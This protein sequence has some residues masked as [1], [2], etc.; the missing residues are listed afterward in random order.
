MTS[1]YLAILGLRIWTR[2]GKYYLWL[3][4]LLFVIL[5]LFASNLLSVLTPGLDRFALRVVSSTSDIG[6]LIS[7]MSAILATILAI[8]FSISIVVIQNAASNYTASILDMYKKDRGTLLF[9]F[10]YVFS[11]IFCVV[12][13]E[14]QDLY[15]IN[16]AIVLF[17][18]AFL[19][20]FFQFLHIIDLIDPRNIIHKA[21][22]ES[23][24][25]IKNIP[26]RIKSTMEQDKNDES[27]KKMASSEMYP[28]FLLHY[29]KS[30]LSLSKHK[31]LQISDVI[32]KASSRR[33]IETSI[34]GFEAL[35]DITACYVEIRKDDPTVEDSFLQYIYDEL[36]SIFQVGID[37]KD[38]ALMQEAI[39]TFEN[40]GCSTLN[41]QSIGDQPN[42]S[43]IMVMKHIFDLGVNSLEQNFA[44]VS[45]QALDSLKTLGTVAIRKTNNSGLA[46]NHVFEIGKIGVQRKSWYILGIALKELK[47]LL[48]EAIVNQV[49]VYHDPTSILNNISDLSK[50]GII[51]KLDQ[52]SITALFP[53]FTEF[54]IQRAAILALEVKNK[55]HPETET[56][57]RELYSKEILQEL[58]ETLNSIE[59]TSAEHHSTLTL[60]LSN[61]CL[62]EIAIV[63]IN[64]KVSTLEEGYKP[65][66]IS[67]VDSMSVAYQ[68]IASYAFDT[69][70]FVPVPGQ[71]VDSIT[72]IGAV[73]LDHEPAI[74]DECIEALHNM[75]LNM[76]KH[77]KNG[78]GVARLAA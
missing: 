13:L 55:Q 35:A 14:C 3:S 76:L 60:W 6:T 78:H 15:V 4:L 68:A 71:I 49:D 63:M 9:F 43:A 21:K 12:A 20:L 36:L 2:V 42:W 30:L 48:F 59:V 47:E 58:V 11:L 19:F 65:E 37:N 66:L 44:D 8:S 74:A 41:I 28:H 61:N 50:L 31:V 64:E 23:V 62:R 51:S 70:W 38:I 7:A 52:N 26:S 40:I 1:L 75:G 57:Q 17:F 16:M 22:K 10:Y 25:S 67:L 56:F 39:R 18:F 77:D 33:E 72:S 5:F 69:N 73:A 54:S 27:T 32:L 34:K 24:K 53:V 45:A 46:A 29:D